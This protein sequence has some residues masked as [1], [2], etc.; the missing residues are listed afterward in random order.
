MGK[1]GEFFMEVRIRAEM[2]NDTYERIPNELKQEMVIKSIDIP[3]YKEIY[4]QSPKWKEA[5]KQLVEAIKNRS[6][7]QDEIRAE[8]KISK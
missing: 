6:D 8:K 2:S 5:N 3:D 7:I 1:S 4:K